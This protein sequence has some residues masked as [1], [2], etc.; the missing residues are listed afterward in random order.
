MQ[1]GVDPARRNAVDA[2]G[3]RVPH[4]RRLLQV[5]TLDFDVSTEAE[6][7]NAIRKARILQVTVEDFV[8]ALEESVNAWREQSR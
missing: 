1:G 6:A 4:R 5:A 3:D 8:V 7:A 2:V